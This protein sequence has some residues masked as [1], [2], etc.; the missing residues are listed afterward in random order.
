MWAKISAFILRQRIPLA[1][2]MLIITLWMGYEG[3]GVRMSYKFGGVL[4]E[5][6]STY[7]EYQQFTQQFSQDGN[8]LVI[9]V[10]DPELW[11]LQNFNKWKKLGEELKKLT[12]PVD[13]INPST[14]EPYQVQVVDSIFSAA[15]CYEMYADTTEQR[16]RFKKIIPRTPTSQEEVDS[17]QNK[18]YN[19]PFYD[20][21]LYKSKS[22]ATLM[23]V[24]VNNDLFN[25]KNRGD[26][27]DQILAKSDQFTKETRIQSHISGLPYVRSVMM[28]KVKGELKF[29]TYLSLLV[30]AILL[31]IFFRS[32]RAVLVC[33]LIIAMGV[34]ISMGTIAL[35]DYE[36]TVLMGLIP[37][38][39]I[40]IGVP[41]CIYLLTKY[42]QEYIRHGNKMRA[43][44]RVIQKVGEAAFMI[45]ATTAVGFATF[46]FVDSDLLKEFGVI[47]AL[48]SML[49]FFI[50]LITFPILFSYTKAPK[51]RHLRHL[52][53][54]WLESLLE[55]LV[56]MITRQRRAIYVITALVTGISIYGIT[57]MQTTGNIV[58]DLPESDRVITDLHWFEKHFNGVMPFEIM[59]KT[60]KKGLITK[61]QV[62]EKIDEMQTVL[63]QYPQFSKSLSIADASKFARQAFYNGDP[64]RYSLIQRGEQSFIGPYFQRNYETGNSQKSFI[65][66]TKTMTRITVQVA[67]IGTIEMQKV[68]TELRP[69]VDSIFSPDKFDVILTGTSVVFVKGTRYLVDNLFSSLLFA[70]IVISLLMAAMFRSARMVLI[71][72]V[73]NIIPQ[74]ITA[75]M[76]GFFDIPLK[77]STILVFSI[78]FGIT[79]DNT[80]H[81]LAKYRQELTL[82]QWNIKDSVLIAVKDTGSSILFTSIVLLA[83]FGIFAFSEFDGT[84]A[85]GILTSLTLLTAML[86]NLVVLPALLLSFQRSLTTKAFAEPFVQ[87]IDEEDDLDYG[88]WEIRK[89]DPTLADEDFIPDSDDEENEDDPKA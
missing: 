62:I 77:P 9:G 23:M 67:D 84:R 73:P 56:G 19:L 49:M 30:S 71:S 53:M 25:S 33:M 8:V 70:V 69:Q 27:I 63:A 26:A 35:F 45:N 5:N 78:A 54:R 3:L 75:G 89:I 32:I 55:K 58:D 17:I 15:H 85:L 34:V 87:I 21:L 43:M 81:F 14:G 18:L 47:S 7:V 59:V 10:N 65:D 76:M 31:F 88:D 40:V 2:V 4:P 39:M 82:L 38:L 44:A 41:N 37:P 24:F 52:D 1:L 68:L 48:N 22:D 28:N 12:M 29:F 86:T 60:K 13:S 79:V 51:R 6:D 64:E 72:L 20:G 16:F 57:L 50:S 74:L 66:S 36:I 80:I 42:H 11:E 83:G 46:I 61:P